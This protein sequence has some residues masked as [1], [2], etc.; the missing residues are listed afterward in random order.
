VLGEAYV[1]TYPGNDNSHPRE[2]GVRYAAMLL[3]DELGETAA[4]YAAMRAIVL[5]KR[6]DEI[7]ASAWRRVAPM[8]DEMQRKRATSSS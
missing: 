5:Q 8:I 7:G 6:G 1:N 2:S 3:I 4:A